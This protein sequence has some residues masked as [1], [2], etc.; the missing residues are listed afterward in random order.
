[1]HTDTNT[2]MIARPAHHDA[3]PSLQCMEI[4]GGIEAV[5]TALSLTG[6][7]AWVFS[8][9]HA[10]GHAGGDIHYLSMCGSG[11]IVRLGLADVSG[12]GAKV[13]QIAGTLRTLMRKH[14]NTPDM[15]RFMRALNGAFV[16]QTQEGEASGHFATAILATYHAPTDHLLLCNAGH[17]RPLWWRAATGRWSA[18]DE[19]SPELADEVANLPLGVIEPTPYSQFAVRLAKGDLVLLFTDGLE[20]TRAPNGVMLGQAGVIAILDTLDPTKP[21]HLLSALLQRVE[22][23]RG[24][25]APA[26]DD[27][28]VI[29]LHH[30]GA[31]PH[32][33]SLGE[34]A[35]VLAKMI[36]LR[37]V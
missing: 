6:L 17:P 13:S 36:G 9:P 26:D 30:N 25:G 14:I 20:E 28:S 11:R 23:Y 10:G 35:G 16:E 2:P 18:L 8:R 21:D 4:W 27:L 12:H 34:I 5:D 19:S 24:E 22:R 3:T 15:T 29:L 37:P 7:D 32:R 33:L 1:M 31:D